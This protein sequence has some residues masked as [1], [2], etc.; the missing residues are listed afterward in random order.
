MCPTCIAQ[1]VLLSLFT[2]VFVTLETILFKGP[3]PETFSIK[4]TFKLASMLLSEFY[5]S[6][7]AA[8]CDFDFI[9]RILNSCLKWAA[10]V[11]STVVEHLPPPEQQLK[12]SWV[13]IPLAV[14][15]LFRN[16]SLS[17]WPSILPLAIRL[18]RSG[19]GLAR[20]SS[21]MALK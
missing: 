18:A 3:A 17:G 13:R 7:E 20:R 8:R 4:F 9:D 6:K 14:L 16:L 15:G 2:S 12:R 21:V 1:T 19:R 11:P 5:R 10:V